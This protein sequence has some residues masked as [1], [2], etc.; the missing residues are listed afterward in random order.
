M[1]S[2]LKNKILQSI[3]N[4]IKSKP[5]DNP[6]GMGIDCP[7]SAA[8]TMREITPDQDKVTTVAE[9]TIKF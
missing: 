1:F 2:R 6:P 4:F 7:D 5:E 9:K 3:L 8:D